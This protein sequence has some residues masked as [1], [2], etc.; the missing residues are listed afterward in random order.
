MDDELIS[1]AELRKRLRISEATYY[2]WLKSG[3][4]KGVRIGRRWRF[5]LAAVEELLS[6]GDPAREGLARAVELC[7]DWLGMDDR[8]EVRAMEHGQAVVD[9]LI[10]RAVAHRAGSLHLE[11]VADGLLVR[12]RVHGVM[13]PAD[14]VLPEEARATIVRTIKGRAGM[15]QEVESLPQDARFFASVEG[16][17]V[18]V[19][20]TVYPTALGEALTLD[21]G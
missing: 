2:R 19:R 4:L 14:E 1:P 21:H 15:N 12:E 9:M 3:R 18:D 6:G 20:G 13:R 11:P 10:E 17:Q 8:S 7:A 5:P 16:R